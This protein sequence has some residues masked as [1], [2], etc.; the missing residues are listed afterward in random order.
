MN[1]LT[2]SSL[3]IIPILAVTAGPFLILKAINSMNKE[4]FKTT[5][6]KIQDDFSEKDSATKTKKHLILKSSSERNSELSV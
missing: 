5:S 6:F 3:S 1:D 4:P 2:I